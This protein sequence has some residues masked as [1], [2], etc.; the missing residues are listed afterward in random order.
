MAYLRPHTASALEDISLKVPSD[1]F[2]RQDGR[3][4][5]SLSL[6]RKYEAAA[7]LPD[8]SI[9]QK[10]HVAPATPLFEEATCAFARG[11]LISTIRG[12]VAVEDL[13]PG[14]YVETNRG[15]ETVVWVGS[16]TFVPDAPSSDSMLT[17]LTRITG[18][19][20][21]PS[22]PQADVLVGPAARMTV[23]REKL[24]SLLGHGAVLAPVHDYADGDRIF[25]VT[26]PGS[27]QLYHLAL[28]TH[29]TIR[30]GGIEMES[31]HPGKSLNATL[32]TNMRALFLSM[33]P[34]IG[35]FEDFGELAY[36]R[37]TRE[38]IDSLTSN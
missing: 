22:L 20:F 33:F 23:R 12:P 5:R 10:T 24:R 32:G 14:D 30:V 7:L 6:M 29:G 13:L 3:P 16:T 25:D 8:L 38:V 2:A 37:T 27:V 9:S 11:S 36:P 15:P 19:A 17:S 18:D 21:G 1:P 28:Q 34:N 26:P 35:M 31:Y 4:R